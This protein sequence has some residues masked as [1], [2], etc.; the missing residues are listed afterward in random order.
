[1]KLRSKHNIWMAYT[2][3]IVWAV[4]IFLVFGND[5]RE[6]SV[7]ENVIGLFNFFKL[8]VFLIILQIP[9]AVSRLLMECP[10]CNNK[11]MR[12]E[13]STILTVFPVL[14][15]PKNCNQCDFKYVWPD[16]IRKLF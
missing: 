5:F 3:T 8:I 1:M 15:T 10:K 6:V 13:L 16:R 7:G 9:L 14:H 12:L 2:A 11:T 4:V